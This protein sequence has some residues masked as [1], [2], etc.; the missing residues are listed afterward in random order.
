M[1][2]WYVLLVGVISGAL[3]ANMVFTP[4]TLLHDPYDFD[5]QEH[6]GI[7]LK[8]GA[9]P[10]ARSAH[11]SFLK[12]S[13]TRAPLATLLFNK[14]DFRMVHIFPDCSLDKIARSTQFYNPYLKVTT[15]NPRVV[16]REEGV[17]FRAELE[18]ELFAGK[19][20]MGVRTT[21]PLQ[22]RSFIKQDQQTR[23]DS[24]T[25]DVFKMQYRSI[26]GSPKVNAFAYR[27]DFL[28]ALP[29]GENGASPIDWQAGS[30]PYSV[31]IF[32][33]PTPKDGKK[34][35]LG[36]MVFEEGHTPHGALVGM[37][38]S[39][40]PADLPEA[41]VTL[42]TGTK[43]KF[44]K[45]SYADYDEETVPSF[46][47]R[48]KL[49]D[50]KARLWV[51]STHNAAG[52]LEPGL[53]SASINTNAHQ[54][55]ESYN[56][57]P[58]EWLYDR[59][60]MFES[61]TAFGCGDVDLEWYY[62]HCFGSYLT[63][64]VRGGGTV[65]V[66]DAPDYSQNPY[67]AHL[68]NAGHSILHAG[69]SVGLALKDWVYCFVKGDYYHA[70]PATEWRAGTAK[71]SLIKNI[72]PRI[73]ADVE[74]RYHTITTGIEFSH[75]YTADVSATLAYQ[76]YD[77]QAD[78]L[79]YEVSQIPSWLGKAYDA[80][81]K[82][83]ETDY[84]MQ[85]DQDGAVAGTARIAH[86]LLYAMTYRGSDWFTLHLQGGITCGGENVPQEFDLALTYTIS[87]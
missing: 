32:S 69:A 24:Q 41:T 39:E 57:N 51:T 81:A 10:Y 46:E 42:L 85:L 26:N 71:G 8:I 7:Q 31:N 55:V 61:D 44:A 59:G 47:E 29:N 70:L 20:V 35:P 49:Q 63:L 22:K 17:E 38:E 19:G 56:S 87:V 9:T 1:S 62:S 75:P 68:G 67:K 18:K 72:G 6:E 76:L 14:S 64:E 27:L 21:I 16:Y 37:L 28:E 80:T 82:G 60:Y 54:L 11:E 5:P 12:G 15:L 53:A 40:V 74:W 43:W 45:R 13:K 50:H 23:R 33:G 2:K 48:V 52:N 3:Q 83:Y 86:K 77:K 25:E 73:A 66:S 30:S 65:A 58:Y 84:Y 34:L 4:L 78:T 36:V 79:T